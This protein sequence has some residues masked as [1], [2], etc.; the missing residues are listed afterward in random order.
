MSYTDEDIFMATL[1][2]YREAADQHD[3]GITAMLCVAKNNALKHDTSIYTEITKA[4]RYSSINCPVKVTNY[5][6]KMA[7]L[8]QIVNALSNFAEQTNTTQW[9][10]WRHI[11]GLVAGVLSGALPDITNG[12]TL[13]YSTAMLKDIPKEWD[14]SKIVF[15]TQIGTQR[16][17]K[18]L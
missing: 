8:Q 16:F 2:A 1:A 10:A 15:T 6:N 11:G 4:F 7:A 3:A 12:A 13:Y 18:E 9:N 17:Y 5:I 14:K